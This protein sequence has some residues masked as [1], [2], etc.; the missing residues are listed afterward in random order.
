MLRKAGVLLVVKMCARFAFLLLCFSSANAQSLGATGLGDVDD[1]QIG[2]NLIQASTNATSES[3]DIN[4]TPF[5]AN[6]FS[7][8]FSGEQE[9]G[10]NPNYKISEG[11]QI[12]LRIWGAYEFNDVVTADTQGN[13]FIPK[14]GPV[15]VVG[16]YNKDLNRRVY[17]AVRSV[18]TNN[19]QVYT[20]LNGTQPVAVFVT[21]YVKK[22]GRYSGTPSNSILYF[23]DRAGG[24]DPQRGSYRKISIV[25]ESEIIVNADLYDFLIDGKIPKLQFQDG[26]TIVV[27]SRGASIKITGDVQNAHRFELTKLKTSGK[28]IS[29]LAQP[30]AGVT[31]AGVSGIRQARP[32]AVYLPIAEFYSMSLEDGDQVNFQIDHRDEIIVVEVEGSY[33]G[34]TRYAVHRNTTL[35]EMLDHIPVDPKLANFRSVSLRRLSI[36]QNQKRALEDSL[37]RLEMR[38]LT[39]SSQTDEEARI[40]AQ[41]VEMIS[42]FVKRARQVQPNGRLVVSKNGSTADITLE[43]GDV[44]T[45]PRKTQAVFVSGEI[46]VSQAI[47][48]SSDNNAMDYI[49][50]VGGFTERAN[51][52]GIVILSPN[53]KV[54]TDPNARI[55]PGDEI[56]VLP[57]VPS[58]NL[59]L[60][61]TVVDI[62]YK[63]A[64]SAAVVLRL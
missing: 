58:K 27:A 57:K 63:I 21:G 22:P 10:L 25:R 18:F 15:K 49:S 60:V 19:V 59:Q 43:P 53:G 42:N 34:P 46:V 29:V 11:D 54:V 5:G 28:A 7:G 31:H 16:V 52:D 37:R 20:S 38:Y 30:A 1:E 51:Q 56:I 3:V 24:V 44:I 4:T 64:V 32:F 13:I 48:F 61:A 2:S 9:N 55:T 14:V 41:E 47:L 12:Y 62:M 23:L 45:I 17:Q 33:L 35:H 26:D 39:A 8:E 6:L 50:R 36:A 40:R